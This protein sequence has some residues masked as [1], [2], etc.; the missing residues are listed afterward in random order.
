MLK[1][2]DYALHSLDHGLRPVICVPETYDVELPIFSIERYRPLM[3]QSG[4]R[5]VEGF[6]VGIE[7]PDL[8]FFSWPVQYEQ[9][10]RRLDPATPHERVILIVQNVRHANPT[11]LDG[12]ALRLLARPQ[13]GRTQGRERA[14][15]AQA[16]AICGVCPVIG[17]CL[18][19]AVEIREPYGIW[20]GLTETERRQA[21]VRRSATS[22]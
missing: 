8:A 18:E 22:V 13:H 21:I 12:Y 17:D 3:R 15:R 14:A 11:F 7:P 1:V 20:G 2:F 10:A 9:I 4:V 16:K 5:H 19:F 6:E